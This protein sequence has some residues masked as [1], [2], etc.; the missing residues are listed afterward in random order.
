MAP[1]LGYWIWNGLLG[2]LFWLL[3]LIAFVALITG[4]VMVVYRAFGGTRGSAAPPPALPPVAVTAA[5]P[6]T[7]SAREILDR[8]LASGEITPQQYD[9]VRARLEAGAT[10][11]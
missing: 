11:S 9:E 7:Q 3:L 4:V 2:F 10:S 6:A 1:P 5:Q 8:R